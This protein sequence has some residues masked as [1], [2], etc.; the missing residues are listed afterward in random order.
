MY[1]SAC[2][3]NENIYA[4]RLPPGTD[5]LE[6]II[7]FCEEHQMKLLDAPISGGTPAAEAGTLAIMAGAIRKYLRQCGIY[8]AWLELLSM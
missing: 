7:D 1:E 3:K 8:S 6:A 2:G 5:V 4:L